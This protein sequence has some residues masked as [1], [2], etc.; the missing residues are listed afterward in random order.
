MPR[1]SRKGGGL[2]WGTFFR[3]NRGGSQ[4]E[5]NY[6]FFWKESSPQADGVAF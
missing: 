6:G 5:R 2:K 4:L 3:S 1:Q